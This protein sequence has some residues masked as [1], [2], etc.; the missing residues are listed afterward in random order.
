[1]V[2]D[3]PEF[4][5]ARLDNDKDVLGGIEFRFQ[6]DETTGV[7]K[8]HS[9]AHDATTEN[10]K[11]DASLAMGVPKLQMSWGV[12]TTHP[13]TYSRKGKQPDQCFWPATRQPTGDQLRGWPTL[14]IET[15]VSESLPKLREDAMWW[16]QNSNGEVCIVLLLS[17]NKNQRTALLEK[18]QL[19]STNTPRPMTRTTPIQLRQQ[20]PPPMPP[21]VRQIP[22]AQQPFAHQEIQLT[23]TSRTGGPL[24]LPFEAL[25]C[26]PPQGTEADITLAQQELLPILRNL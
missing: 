26:R 10:L 11:D 4:A 6:F 23:Q 9:A 18:W 21:L 13:G 12:T 7:I 20:V 5:R 8:I 3:L 19:A 25:F 16:F 15:G 17:I 14:V 2:L 22:M 1:M 24:V